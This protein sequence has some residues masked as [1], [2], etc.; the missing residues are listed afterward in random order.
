MG[1]Q[2]VSQQTP[3]SFSVSIIHPSRM[4]LST[5]NQWQ[6]ERC[7][8]TCL[9]TWITPHVSLYLWSLW[10]N[11]TWVCGDITRFHTFNFNSLMQFNFIFFLFLFFKIKTKQVIHSLHMVHFCFLLL[12]ILNFLK[13][14]FYDWYYKEKT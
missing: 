12:N 10:Q 2:W 6:N 14:F 7:H 3:H 13:D 8:V 11:T 4:L 5:F 1:I 9:I